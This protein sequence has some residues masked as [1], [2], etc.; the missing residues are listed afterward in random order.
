MLV[1]SL[2]MDMKILFFVFQLFLSQALEPERKPDR[3]KSKKKMLKL[4]SS[5]IETEMSRAV[6]TVQRGPVP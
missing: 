4:N 2:D 6:L 3:E 1:L 5:I